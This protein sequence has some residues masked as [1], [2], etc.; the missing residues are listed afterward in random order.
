MSLFFFFCFI[1]YSEEMMKRERE[2]E[3]MYKYKRDE[4]K[5]FQSVGA[6]FSVSC[7]F[8]QKTRVLLINFFFRKNLR[9]SQTTTEN[10][11]TPILIENNRF[12]S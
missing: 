3:S 7:C 6:Y 11:T 2:R 1:Y 10:N 9:V 4:R 8:K 12:S 5:Q